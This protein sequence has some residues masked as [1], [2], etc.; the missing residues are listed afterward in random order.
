M[1]STGNFVLDKGYAA[2]AALIKYRAV[3]MTAE[4]TVSPVT[5]K[6]DVV[7]GVPQFDVATLE[8]TK[9]KLEVLGSR[10]LPKW[11]LPDFA[12]WEV[13]VDLPPTVRFMMLSQVIV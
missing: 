2:S 8:I 10:E 4:E 12:L 3:K 1:P 5:T 9:G 11:K 6:T 13:F 7:I